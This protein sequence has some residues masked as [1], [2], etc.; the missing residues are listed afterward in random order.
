M[1]AVDGATMGDLALVLLA[2]GLLRVCSP[3]RAHWIL[4]RLGQLLPE[5]E[6]A[7]DA[8]R[9]ARRIA[10]HGTCLS[11]SLAIA[12]RAPTADVVIGVAPAPGAPLLAHAW[13]EMGGAPL[14]AQDMAGDVI[15]RLHGPRA[16]P[17]R[18]SRPD[19]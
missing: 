13:I 17:E 18:A 3:L 16:R 1:E 8:R 12:S 7:A 2:R 9:V 11:R 4:V 19:G 15:A 14:E 10:G 5:I 6:T